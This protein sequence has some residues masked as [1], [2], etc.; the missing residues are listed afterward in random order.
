MT[1][2]GGSAAPPTADVPTCGS[3]LIWQAG[4]LVKTTFVCELRPGHSGPHG[5]DDASWTAIDPR[6]MARPA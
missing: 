4:H 1:M 3:Q 5:N 6:A 2:D